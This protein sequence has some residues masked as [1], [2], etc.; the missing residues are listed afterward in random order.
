[1]SI[2]PCFSKC[3]PYSTSLSQEPVRPES[4]APPGTQR[5]LDEIPRELYVHASVIRAV[6]EEYLSHLASLSSLWLNH[7]ISLGIKRLICKN[8]FPSLFGICETS[9]PII[10]FLTFVELFS[11][12]LKGSGCLHSA[13]G[14]ESPQSP[15]GMHRGRPGLSQSL[16]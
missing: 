6:I 15:T 16:L 8:C 10:S 9:K 14:T 5:I 7:L 12:C 11:H 3:G 1:M 13:G 4:E 2:D